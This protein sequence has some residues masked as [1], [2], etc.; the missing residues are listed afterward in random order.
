ML[1]SG[2]FSSFAADR[3]YLLGFRQNLTSI[4]AVMAGHG[5]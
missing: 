4:L 2:S 5:G 1:F 3:A